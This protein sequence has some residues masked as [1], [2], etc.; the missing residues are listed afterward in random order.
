MTVPVLVVSG[1]LGA[2]KTT[3]INRLL[4][5]SESRR[6]SAIVNDFGAINI[7]AELIA[8]AADTVVGLKNGCICCS[9]QGDLLRTL[10]LVLSQPVKP[11]HIIVEAS[12]VA[13]PRGIVDALMDPILW[14]A[15]RL[16]AV[17]SVVDADDIA[18]T[19]GRRQDELW[20]AQLAAADFVALSKTRLSPEAGETA[21]LLRSELAAKALVFDADDDLP[22]EALFVADRSQPAQDAS[23]VVASRFT[24]VE[25][26]STGAVHLD[27]FQAAMGELATQL[28]RAKGIVNFVEQ[29]GRSF[30]LQMVGRRASLQPFSRYEPECRLVLIGE[31]TIFN[32][33]AAYT[34]L[35]DMFEAA[36]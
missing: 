28:I 22:I 35:S 17:V 5:R 9:L 36:Q 30:L 34:L 31:A 8:D 23:S 14:D 27:R 2:G 33:E 10:K 12:G 26:Q 16:D 13:D 20:R 3:F 6:I 25:W 32:S 18:A 7:D 19:P 11:D 4:A 1:F 29:P 15:T 21:N 24:S